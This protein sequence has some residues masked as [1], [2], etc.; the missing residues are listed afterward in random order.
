MAREPARLAWAVP[1]VPR[2]ALQQ[3]QVPP[4]SWSQAWQLLE[5]AMFPKEAKA[6]RELFSF[7][8]ELSRRV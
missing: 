5:E 6:W 4:V 7:R 2:D 1:D 8:I 3:L